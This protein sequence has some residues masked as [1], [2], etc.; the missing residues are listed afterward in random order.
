MKKVALLILFACTL[1]STIYTANFQQVDFVLAARLNPPSKV[2]EAAEGLAM[3]KSQFFEVRYAKDG[4]VWTALIYNYFEDGGFM[5][6]ELA[7]FKANG[8]RLD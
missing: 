2:V 1:S 7:Q 3:E 4:G 5:D 8:K 6:V